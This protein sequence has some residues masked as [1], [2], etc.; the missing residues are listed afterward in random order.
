MNPQNSFKNC[1]N[2]SDHADSL[3][4]KIL[5]LLSSQTKIDVDVAFNHTASL[6]GDLQ[7]VSQTTV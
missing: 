3:S 1:Y 7:S 6:K 5:F 2:N 4:S